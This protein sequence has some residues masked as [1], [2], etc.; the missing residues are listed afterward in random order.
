M[1]LTVIDTETSGVSLKDHELLEIGLISYVVT[2]DGERLI[3]KKF[4]KK[5]KPRHI[6]T[7]NHRALEINGYNKK[8]WEGAVF[9]E[10]VLPEVT[11]MIEKSSVLMGQNLIFD[12]RFFEKAYKENQVSVPKFPPYIDTKSMADKL[13]KIGILKKSGMDYLCEH[14]NIKFDGR[15]HTA[16]AD[17]ERTAKA[18]DALLEYEPD[19]D[20]WTFEFPYE[21]WRR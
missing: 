20:L 17:C 4:E 3:T 2:N 10:E 18:F 1:I 8:E 19:Y 5:I 14:F 16:I 13:R 15:A 11:E 12:L 21:P 6:H 9:I 7:A